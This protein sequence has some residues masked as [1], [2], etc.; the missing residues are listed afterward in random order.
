[1]ACCLVNLVGVHGGSWFAGGGWPPGEGVAAYCLVNLV[2]M[3]GGSW[4]AAAICAIFC[5]FY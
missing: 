1:V 3:R 2:G 4:F 5:F